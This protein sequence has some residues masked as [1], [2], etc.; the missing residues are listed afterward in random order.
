MLSPEREPDLGYIDSYFLY[1]VESGEIEF[2][3]ARI[4]DFYGFYLAVYA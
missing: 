2:D 1:D 4:S 3:E